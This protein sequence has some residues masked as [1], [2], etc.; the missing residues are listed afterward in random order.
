MK[1]VER[2]QIEMVGMS[3]GRRCQQINRIPNA[4]LFNKTVKAC[5]RRHGHA[6]SQPASYPRCHRVNFKWKQGPGGVWRHRQSFDF[7]AGSSDGGQF[8]S[9]FHG[10]LLFMWK[11]FAE[12]ADTS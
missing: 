11:D 3:G 10:F 1:R 9:D 2:I 12:P 7:M 8:L 4:S 5:E 6:A